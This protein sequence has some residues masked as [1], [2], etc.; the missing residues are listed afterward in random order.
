[1]KLRQLLANIPIESSAVDLETEIGEVR[2]DSRSVQPGDLFV[3]IRGYATDGHAFIGMALA[4][5]A[6]AVLCEEA[7]KGI[8]A[9][10]VKNSRAALADLAANR[11]GHPADRLTMIGVTGTNGKTTTTTLVK[12]ILETEGHKVGLIGTNQNM[13]GDEIVPT[14]RT[15]PESYELQALFA[16]MADAGC[17]HC[18]MEVSSHSLVLDRVRGVRFRVGAFTNL[19]QDHLDFHHTMEEY[20]RAKARLFSM[21]DT[22]VINADDPVAGQM[23]ADAACPCLTFSAQADQQ[24][25]L[26]ASDIA[27]HADGVTFRAAFR[28]QTVPVRLGIPGHFSVENALTAMGICLALDVPADRI[29][30]ALATAHGVKGRAEVVPTDTDYTILIDYAHAPD[31]VDNILRTVQGFAKGRVIAVFGCGGDRDRTK[32][33]IMGRIA[34]ELADYCIVTSDNPR[35]EEPQAIIDEILTGMQDAKVPVEAICDRPSA[36]H[37]AMDIAQA[38][39]VIVLMGKGHE[40]YQEINHVKHHMDEREIVQ[41][42]FQ[43]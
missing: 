2:Y 40:T 1:M 29:A 35:T 16:R 17:T 7:G 32:R 15:T 20:R 33:P 37:H 6:A 3:A 43:K 30:A 24:A 26:T 5:G 21:C 12:H 8:P 41:D 25:D 38:G 10:V 31:G 34:A 18:V 4:K 11:F 27:L 19:T 42:Y 13:I 9:I 28:G 22:G 36:I 39:D 14:E 23:L